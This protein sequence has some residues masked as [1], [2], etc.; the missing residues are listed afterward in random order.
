M[1]PDQRGILPSTSITPVS[2]TVKRIHNRNSRHK[3]LTVHCILPKYTSCLLHNNCAKN[4]FIGKNWVSE[5]HALAV[6]LTSLVLVVYIEK[7]INREIIDYFCYS[8]DTQHHDTPERQQK[9]NLKIII[10]P[11]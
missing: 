10:L 2:I 4:G 7:K 8:C 9:K 1:N 5:S 11:R 6:L 3:T